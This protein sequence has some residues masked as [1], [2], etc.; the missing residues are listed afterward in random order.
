MAIADAGPCE[1]A[2]NPTVRLYFTLR[3]AAD[4]AALLARVMGELR[5]LATPAHVKVLNHPDA[6][7]RRDPFVVYLPAAAWHRHREAFASIHRDHVSAVRDDGPRLARRLGRGWWLAEEPPT[8]GQRMSFGQH[9]CLV[10]ARG[11]ISA[12]SAGLTDAVGRLR[13]IREALRAH[14]VDPDS[15]HRMLPAGS[16]R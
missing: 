6:Y 1:P 7:L 4:A 3:E 15:P 5:R 10:I 11:L 13:S 12:H 14:G 16:A 9:R 2:A 8:T